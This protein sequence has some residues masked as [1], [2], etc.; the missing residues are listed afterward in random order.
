MTSA[1]NRPKWPWYSNARKAESN[2]LVVNVEII[3][4]KNVCHDNFKFQNDETSS[5]LNNSP[6]TGA[7]KADETPAAIP[8]EI[9]FRL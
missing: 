7:P 4:Q 3:Q 2:K 5:I 1:L 6:P 8:A 9:K